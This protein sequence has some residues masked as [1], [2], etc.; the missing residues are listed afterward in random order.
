MHSSPLA[1]FLPHTSTFCILLVPAVFKFGPNNNFNIRRVRNGTIQEM[2][3]ERV[4]KQDNK[5]TRH[6]YKLG[7][8]EIHLP[9]QMVLPT[10]CTNHSSSLS[11]ILFKNDYVVL[12]CNTM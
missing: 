5:S 2:K 1:H 7:Q 6:I 8:H 10:T 12:G 4:T 3:M 11:A 9:S